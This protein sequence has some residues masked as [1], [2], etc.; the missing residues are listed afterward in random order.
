MRRLVLPGSLIALAI[1]GLILTGSFGSAASAGKV[2]LGIAASAKESGEGVLVQ[3]VSPDSPAAQAGLKGGDRIVKVENKDVK[4]FADL[5]SILAAH[6][7]GDKITLE[8]KRNQKQEKFAITLAN[9]P[10]KKSTNEGRAFSGCSN[11]APE[12]RNEGTPGSRCGPG[13][14]GHPCDGEFTGREGRVGRRR[15]HHPG[16]YHGHRQSPRAAGGN[17]EGGSGQG[18]RARRS[19]AARRRRN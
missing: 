11:S 10:E 18:G 13:R 16:R 8:V 7:A 1:G 3:H 17:P 9:H 15:C 19:L 14:S 6:K 5:E 12:Q 2:Y 4:T